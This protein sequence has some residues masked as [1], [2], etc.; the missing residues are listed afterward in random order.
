MSADSLFISLGQRERLTTWVRDGRAVDQ[1]AVVY[2]FPA[3]VARTT[4]RAAWRSILTRYANLR[5]AFAG[6]P[7][8][9][10]VATAR[11]TDEV[12]ERSFVETPEAGFAA[13]MLGDLDI[14]G[15]VMARLVVATDA[16]T[17]LVGACFDHLVVDGVT[18]ANILAD[19]WS[20]L[21]GGG[22]VRP[23][24]VSD[25]ETI[26]AELA[27]ADSPAAD[28]ILRY[29][30]ER[31]GGATYPA[32]REDLA[33]APSTDD[34][35]SERAEVV[36]PLPPGRGALGSTQ[37]GRAAQVLA[38]CTGAMGN[39]DRR[40]ADDAPYR[41]LIQAARRRTE[42]DQAIAGF[43]SNWLLLTIQPAVD[44]DEML[45]RSAAALVR[46]LG[47]H[48]IHH[49]EVV[50]RLEPHRYGDRYRSTVPAEPYGLFNYLKELPAARIGA[51]AGELLSPPS[52]GGSEIHGALRIYAFERGDL[53]TVRLRVFA[54][55]RILGPG[56]AETVV[57]QVASRCRP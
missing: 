52:A 30:R 23:E 55:P 32:L 48:H 54:D 45:R 50:R 17:T 26:R 16:G 7:E 19:L 31:T 35:T 39:A 20:L 43:L 41:M 44:P 2:R 13:A 9:G 1:P 33:A 42:A 29:W 14:S 5:T 12:F 15:G 40:R 28:R 49:A 37:L 34:A 25:Q 21:S 51:L 47:T 36:L 56:Y 18:I 6:S 24:P 10:F 8:E 38:L 27:A 57:E 53:G 3:V 4:F 11:P 46:S 22:A